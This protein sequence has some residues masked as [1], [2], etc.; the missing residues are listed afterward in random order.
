MENKEWLKESE[1][2]LLNK[3]KYAMLKLF[4]YKSSQFHSSFS[5]RQSLEITNITVEKQKKHLVI[6][7]TLGHPD[8][9]IGQNEGEINKS[10]EYIS[11]ITGYPIKFKLIESKLWEIDYN[12]L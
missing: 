11:R 4:S 1:T 8:L 2:V 5:I 10:T 9:F 6:L 7:I 12:K 3:V